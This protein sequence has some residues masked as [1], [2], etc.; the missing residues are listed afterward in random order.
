[1]FLLLLSL[2][3]ISVFVYH[4]ILLTNTGHTVG[5]DGPVYIKSKLIFNPDMKKEVWRFLSYMFV[6]SGYFHITFNIVVQVGFSSLADFINNFL[7]L[8]DWLDLDLID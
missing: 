8:T 1:M 5:A 6:H 4:V 3:Q 2:G 7:P